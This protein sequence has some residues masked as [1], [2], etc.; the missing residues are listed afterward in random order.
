MVAVRNIQRITRTMQMIATA[1]FTSALQR[2]QATQPYASR[3]RRM[4]A[5]VAAVE[6][7][8]D[9]PLLAAPGDRKGRELLLV[10]VSDRGLCGAYNGNVLR[11]ALQHVRSTTGNST[12]VVLETSG[13]KANAFFRFTRVPV[14]TRHTVF[15]DKP[16]YEEV[17]RLADRY[18]QQFSA[19]EYDAIRVAY[20]RFQS[21]SRQVP[22]IAQLLPLSSP[23]EDHETTHNEN[24][25]EPEAQFEFTPSAEELLAVLLPESVKVTLFQAFNDAVV[26]EQVMR[27]VAM[28]AA[29]DN[30]K[31]L[32]KTLRRQFNRARQSQITTELMEVIAGA[33]ALE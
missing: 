7:D 22:E 17:R 28:K 12:E 6:K 3:I 13:K 16:A 33:A 5:D 18:I 25:G 20:T 4:V 21:A 29:T 23:A 1:K 15:G 9:H 27:M 26:S 8:T 10:I 19:G 30:A 2:A 14:A 31:D 11:M 24:G 32:G